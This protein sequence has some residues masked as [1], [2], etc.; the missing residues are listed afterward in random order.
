MVPIMQIDFLCLLLLLNLR[1][2]KRFAN[3]T[4]IWQ[5]MYLEI[6]SENENHSF[7]ILKYLKLFFKKYLY[8]YVFSPPQIWYHNINLYETANNPK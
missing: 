3:H 5:S 6:L 1:P 8:M 2:A 7:E 4:I